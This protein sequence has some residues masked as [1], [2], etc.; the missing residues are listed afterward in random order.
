MDGSDLDTRRITWLHRDC[1]LFTGNNMFSIIHT[2]K[3]F[4]KIFCSNPAA[5]WKDKDYENLIHSFLVYNS[6]LSISF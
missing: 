5:T 3:E 2:D 1:M 6:T 4:A